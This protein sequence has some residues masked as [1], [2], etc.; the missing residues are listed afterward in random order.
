[1]QVDHDIYSGLGYNERF[2]NEQ[3]QSKEAGAHD[4]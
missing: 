2:D 3:A 1:M 4:R